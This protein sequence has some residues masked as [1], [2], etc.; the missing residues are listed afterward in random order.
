MSGNVVHV[1]ATIMCPHMGTV[2]AITSNARVFVSGQ[3]VVTVSDTFTVSGCTFLM[4]TPSPQPCILAR[5]LVPSA[6]I[7]VNGQ[8]AILKTSSGIC[9]SAAQ[10]PQGPPNVLVTQPGVKGM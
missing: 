3:P 10:A 5:W 1:G 6:R 2:T 9:Q 8:S 7:L 4:T